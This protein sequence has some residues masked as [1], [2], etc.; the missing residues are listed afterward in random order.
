VLDVSNRESF[1][2]VSDWNKRIQKVFRPSI[3]KVLIANKMDLN[4]KREFEPVEA[5]KLA[6]DLGFLG[7]YEVSA[8]E[9][10][11]VGKPIEDLLQQLYFLSNPSSEHFSIETSKT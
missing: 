6:K 1:D 8:K 5:H 3:V 2:K 10:I 11:N 9:N 7:Y 4:Q